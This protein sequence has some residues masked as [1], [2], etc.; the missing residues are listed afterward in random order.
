[1]DTP[2]GSVKT[3]SILDKIFTHTRVCE[4]KRM[5]NNQDGGDKMMSISIL[6]LN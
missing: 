5:Q 4:M 3:W 2:L 6:K 1:M